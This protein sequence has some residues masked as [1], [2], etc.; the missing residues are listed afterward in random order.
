M[1]EMVASASLQKLVQG[2]V[3]ETKNLRGS[4]HLSWDLTLGGL[5]RVLGS[6]YLEVV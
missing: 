1:M 6:Y 2:L 3:L 5:K 4:K